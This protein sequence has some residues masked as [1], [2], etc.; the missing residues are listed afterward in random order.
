MSGQSV[1]RALTRLADLTAE[2]V[3]SAHGGVAA[4]VRGVLRLGRDRSVVVVGRDGT[5]A[6]MRLHESRFSGMDT[7]GSQLLSGSYEPTT[8]R[9]LEALVTSGA[10]VVDVGANIG[11]FT[12]LSALLAGPTGRVIAFEPEPRNHAVLTDNVARNG[13]RQVMVVQAACA[14]RVGQHELSINSSETG[15]HRLVA[16]GEVGRGKRVVVEVTTVDTIVGEAPVD[17]VKIDVEGHEGAVVTGMAQTLADN[18]GITVILEHSPAQARL[19]GLDPLAPVTLLHQAG[20]RHTY[21]VR[22]DK[23]VLEKID[24]ESLRSRDV[25]TGRSV[26][27][28]MRAQSWPAD[29]AVPVV[30]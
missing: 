22:E 13:L 6:T 5:S 20:L 7:I 19:A 12:V 30:S 18:P 10:T 29:S 25:K 1:S 11:Y 28:V 3:G 26:N 8:R 14:D 27:L 4:A 17:V 21:V 24:V 16:A 2:A 23:A 15:W 9:V